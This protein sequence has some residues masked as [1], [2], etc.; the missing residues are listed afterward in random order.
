M[1]SLTVEE[2]ALAEIE[3]AEMSK[4]GDAML[5]QSVF[6]KSVAVSGVSSA[7]GEYGH[8]ASDWRLMSR[9]ELYSFGCYVENLVEE[10]SLEKYA[11]SCVERL[12]PKTIHN[13]NLLLSC[14]AHSPES[15]AQNKLRAMLAGLHYLWNQLKSQNLV[16]C[17]CGYTF[18]LYSG[19]LPSSIT[20]TARRNHEIMIDQICEIAM[21]LE[22][23]KEAAM[24]L[25]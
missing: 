12:V 11:D 5:Y 4:F 21:E 24:E 2:R 18:V 16:E 10:Q 17:E 22:D 15:R 1:Q 9:N 6:S 25:S 7:M 20:R 13:A 8:L 3:K 19:F 23:E 14:Y